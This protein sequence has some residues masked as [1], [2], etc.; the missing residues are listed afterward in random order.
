MVKAERD[1]DLIA[2]SFESH[3]QGG[4]DEAHKGYGCILFAS[5]T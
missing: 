5:F 2:G 1:H 4:T 3:S